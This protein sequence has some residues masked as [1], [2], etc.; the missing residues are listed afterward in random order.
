MDLGVDSEATV[1]ETLDEMALPQWTMTVQQCSMQSRGQ[2]QQLAD[3]AGR[4]QGGSAQV[5]LEVE[6]AVDGLGEGGAAAQQCGGRCSEGTADVVA[7]NEF[8]IDVANIVS[9]CAVGRLENLQTSDMHR[10][11]ARFAEQ[12]H[13][14]KRRY[15]FHPNCPSPFA[16]PR[17]AY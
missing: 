3:A 11:L 10:V 6:F 16:A 12:K 13:R 5:I 4:G 2:F 15:Q 8:L 7:H 1:I 9:T 17:C 14:V